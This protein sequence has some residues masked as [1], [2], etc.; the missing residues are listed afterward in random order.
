VVQLGGNARMIGAIVGTGSLAALAARPGVGGLIDR[1]GRK[2][3]ALWFLA[4]DAIAISLYFPIHSIGWPIFVVRAIHGAVEGTARVALFAMVYEMLPRGREGEAMATFSLCGQ[5]PAA[6]APLLGEQLIRSLGFTVFF[7]LA[8]AIVVA[9]AIVVS[10][11]IEPPHPR[12]ES[13]EPIGSRSYKSLFT[14]RKLMPLWIVTLMFSVALAARLSFV[15][16]FA[17]QQGVQRAGW[18]FAIYSLMAVAVRLGGGQIM[19]RIGLNRAL[20]PSLALLAL[21]LALLAGTGKFG[22]LD[23]AA[24]IGGIGHGYLYPALSALVIARTPLA[25]TGRSSSIYSS[26]YDLGSMAGPYLLGIVAVT[27]G[28]GPMFIIAGSIAMAGAIYFVIAEPDA[29]LKLRN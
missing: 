13:G 7:A 25:S 3:T 26:L 17:Y 29:R 15:A 24:V 6:L 8:I 16:P 27:F 1:R 22:L 23:V 19:D 10:F 2:W 14:D 9:A 12:H 11:V 28:Y 20:A 5:V 4:L 18:Y 21:G